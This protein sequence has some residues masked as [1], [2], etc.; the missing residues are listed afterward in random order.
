VSDMDQAVPTSPTADPAYMQQYGKLMEAISSCRHSHSRAR[1]AATKR[2]WTGAIRR[3]E[4]QARELACRWYREH[5]QPM[6]KA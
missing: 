6:P 4:K 2:Y 5:G 1:D 3:F